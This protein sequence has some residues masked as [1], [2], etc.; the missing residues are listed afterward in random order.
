MWRVAVVVLQPARRL[1]AVHPGQRQ[2]HQDDVGQQLVRL[3]DR[4]DAVAGLGDVETGELQV[5]RV[6]LARVLVVLDHEHERLFR[7]GWLAH[8]RLAFA[9]SRSVNVE[10]APG[11]ALE[12]D[13][14]AEHLRQAAAD[15]QA[16]PVPP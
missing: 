2:I 12:L 1:P 9:G 5:R 16:E 4:L 3:L 15:R 13:R 14:A 8:R 7:L 6:H 11:V 10:P